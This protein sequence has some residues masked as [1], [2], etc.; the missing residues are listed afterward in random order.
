MPVA[1]F[2]KVCA[3]GDHYTPPPPEQC[4]LNFLSPIINIMKLILPVRETLSSHS[5]NNKVHMLLHTEHTVA[6]LTDVV[7]VMQ[8]VAVR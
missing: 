6:A 7:T 4:V 2:L 3:M 8:C 5:S 1:T